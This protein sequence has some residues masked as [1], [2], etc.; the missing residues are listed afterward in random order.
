[1]AMVQSGSRVF[2]SG[3]GLVPETEAGDQVVR[4]AVKLLG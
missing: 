4:M 3:V 2:R 1:M